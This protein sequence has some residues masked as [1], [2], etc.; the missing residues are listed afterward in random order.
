MSFLFFM[1]LLRAQEPAIPKRFISYGFQFSTLGWASSFT[2]PNQGSV[3]MSRTMNRGIA[4]MDLSRNGNKYSLS[5]NTSLGFH[6]SFS[7]QTNTRDLL[8]FGLGI[9]IN[10]S[11][12]S[13]TLP[14]TIIQKGTPIRFWYENNTYFAC[15][16]SL[17]YSWL[18][19]SSNEK[20]YP[21]YTYFGISAGLSAF[22]SNF[23][24]TVSKGQKEEFMVEGNGLKTEYLAA[25]NTALMFGAEVGQ[26]FAVKNGK[27]SLELGLIYFW[28]PENTYVKQVDFYGNG[29]QLGGARVDL[30]GSMIVINCRYSFNRILQ[31]HLRDTSPAELELPKYQLMSLN[32]RA[33]E[34]QEVITVSKPQ[35][36]IYISDDTEL[37][38]D[39][40]SIYLNTDLILKGHELTRTRKKI[41]IDLIPGANYF[42]VQAVDL[43]TS[44]PVITAVRVY[45]NDIP[46]NR[47]LSS[48][49]QTSGSWK[50]IYKP[51]KIN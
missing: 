11:S 22:H 42:T 21:G 32:G 15:L 48:D 46:K 27:N 30:R 10:R 29:S 9:F 44:P 36:D 16:P 5:A 43:G 34:V 31:K 24:K 18:N 51:R 50:I 25:R 1:N 49:F 40:V 14:Y 39:F 4:K 47:H 33:V 28:S 19:G 7:R 17:R 2:E 12:Y 37:D 41:T 3:P 8:S 26:R 6:A 38:G 20:K 45:K 13:F 23:M 35:I